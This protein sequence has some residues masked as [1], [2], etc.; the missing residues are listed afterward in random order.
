MKIFVGIG[1]AL[2]ASALAACSGKEA[3][4]RGGWC[5]CSGGT[6]CKQRCDGDGNGCRQF[7]SEM[8]HCEST[9][10]DECNVQCNSAKDCS[11]QC[12]QR[13]NFICYDSVSCGLV[14]GAQCGYTCYNMQ[15]CSVQ[16]GPGSTLTCVNAE[17]CVVEC[18]GD[19]R[20]FCTDAVG[21]CEV[22]CPGGVSPVSCAD[23]MLACG[24]C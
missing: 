14:C 10:G 17:R 11:T 12:G 23:G 20:V 8:D 21:S 6:E 16:A 7:C 15:T 9:C 22:T 3:C 18:L 24:A 1:L 5:A 19:C 4:V 2:L 13:C